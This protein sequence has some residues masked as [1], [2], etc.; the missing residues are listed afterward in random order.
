M[1]FTLYGGGMDVYSLTLRMDITRHFHFVAT[2]QEGAGVNL[3][4]IHQHVIALIVNVVETLDLCLASSVT[5]SA[6]KVYTHGFHVQHCVFQICLC[7]ERIAAGIQVAGLEKIGVQIHQHVSFYCLKRQ[8]QGSKCKGSVTNGDMVHVVEVVPYICQHVDI[9][10]V[11]TQD[12]APGVEDKAHIAYLPIRN[13]E[14]HGGGCC[15]LRLLLRGFFPQLY[16][17]ICVGYSEAV[18]RVLPSG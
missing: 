13:M 4:E 15:I 17:D 8:E 12:Q 3:E 9:Q 6:V 5:G 18:K 2:L 14:G 7:S 16:A 11:R 10:R 1:H